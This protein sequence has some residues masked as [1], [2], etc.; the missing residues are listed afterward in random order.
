[1]N[2]PIICPVLT[3]PV[4]QALGVDGLLL[5]H[6][7]TLVPRGDELFASTF[8]IRSQSVQRASVRSLDREQLEPRRKACARTFLF[9]YPSNAAAAVGVS[10]EDH[11]STFIAGVHQKPQ[12]RKQQHALLS[13]RR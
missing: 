3:H 12:R 13:L 11:G 7:A 6:I 9:E 1:M 4:Q 2:T 10:D 5:K 8:G